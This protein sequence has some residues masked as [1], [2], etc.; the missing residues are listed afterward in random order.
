MKNIFKCCLN[1]KVLGGIAALVIL[2]YIF[3]PELARYSGLLIL[4]VCPLSMLLMMGAMHHTGK[5]KSFVCSECDLPYADKEWARKCQSW[6][7]E[8]KTCNIEITEHS[9]LK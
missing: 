9:L 5:K 4:L 2:L 6:C 1:P 7:K 3:A 8:H